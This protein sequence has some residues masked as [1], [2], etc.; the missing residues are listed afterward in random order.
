[1]DGKD[2][3]RRIEELQRELQQRQQRLQQA[4]N[5]AN[6]ETQSI[7]SIRGGLTELKKVLPNKDNKSKK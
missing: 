2:I 3:K 7:I 6:Q 1:M 4:Q 5:I